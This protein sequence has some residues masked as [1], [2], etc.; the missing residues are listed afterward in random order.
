MNIKKIEKVIDNVAI[1]KVLFGAAM[2]SCSALLCLTAGRALKSNNIESKEEH[3]V[4]NGMPYTKVT[5]CVNPIVKTNA[6]GTIEYMAPSN[7]TAV[8]GSGKNMT[9]YIT[10]IEPLTS[11]EELLLTK[12]H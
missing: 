11:K 8:S 3:V 9:C 1:K 5:K 12:G 6:D 7:A 2:A 10:V 4:I